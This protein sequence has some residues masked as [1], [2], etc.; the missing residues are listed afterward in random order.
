MSGKNR[1]LVVDDNGDAAFTLATLLG[2][3]GF[4]VRTADCGP[5]ALDEAR[6]F[7]PDACVLD[8]SMPGMDG[9]ELARRLRGQCPGRPP[10]LATMTGYDDHAHLQRAADAGFDLHFTKGGGPGT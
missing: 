3:A 8:I 4:E 9:Y 2:A 6:R 10:V 5:S 1:V 7:T